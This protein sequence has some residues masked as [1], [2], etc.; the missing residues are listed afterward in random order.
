MVESGRNVAVTS[1]HKLT[2]G[3][4]AWQEVA[5]YL[6]RFSL[7]L[8][9]TVHQNKTAENEYPY[10]HY[11]QVHVTLLHINPRTPD[12]NVKLSPNA[13]ITDWILSCNLKCPYLFVH[14]NTLTPVPAA[15]ISTCLC[16]PPSISQ[17]KNLSTQKWIRQQTGAALMQTKVM[18]LDGCLI[19]QSSEPQPADMT[20]IDLQL[21]P[22]CA[23][24]N[25]SQ[26][27]QSFRSAYNKLFINKILLKNRYSTVTKEEQ[28][29][30]ISEF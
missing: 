26:T 13:Q 21:D 9:W 6:F 8:L 20:N 25:V 29:T 11:R 2:G 7:T 30:S 5:T 22:D 24:H 18:E 28:R 4:V 15:L 10:I 27:D 3:R 17:A 14:G 12:L 19:N 1:F 23:G 16:S